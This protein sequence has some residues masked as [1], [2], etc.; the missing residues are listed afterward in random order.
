ML[1]RVFLAVERVMIRRSRVV[2]V[3]CPSLED[4]VRQIDPS[5]RLVLIENAPGSSE[6]NATADDAATVRRRFKLSPAT[7]V[8]LYTGTFEAYQGL[9]LLFEAMAHVHASMPAASAGCTDGSAL[10]FSSLSRRRGD[11]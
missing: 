10:V 9:E 4:T 11:A 1:R 2:I 8:V 3:I 5:A 7:P 6:Q